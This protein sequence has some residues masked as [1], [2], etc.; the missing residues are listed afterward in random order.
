RDALQEG[1]ARFHGSQLEPGIWAKSEY[2]TAALRL[3]PQPLE[4]R[5]LT[6]GFLWRRSG[7]GFRWHPARGTCDG[8]R[9]L[10][11]NSSGAMRAVRTQAITW[12]GIYGA[13]RGG[14]VGWA[15][16]RTCSQPQCARFGP[17]A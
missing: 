13:G 2:R 11:P 16:G 5:I 14:R 3:L 10:D 17:Y 9:R 15:I 12:P 1:R 7:S 6:W 4:S 8:W